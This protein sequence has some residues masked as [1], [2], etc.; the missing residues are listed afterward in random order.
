LFYPNNL[1]LQST[2]HEEHTAAHIT[3]SLDV[4][5]YYDNKIKQK[6]FSKHYDIPVL[7]INLEKRKDRR[8]KMEKTLSIFPTVI[9]IEADYVQDNGALG[10]LQS[11]IKMLKYAI[12]HYPGKDVL[13]CEDD[14]DFVGQKGYDPRTFLF[15]F[16]EKKMKWDTLLLANH[17]QQSVPTVYKDL[18]RTFDSQT[19]S[20]Y[21]VRAGY[22]QNLLNVF[23]NSIAVYNSFGIWNNLTNASDQCWKVLQKVDMWLVPDKTI[24]KQYQDYSDIQK[25]IVNY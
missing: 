13:F 9:R 5:R 17:T 4:V 10:C 16:F 23:E 24:A 3:R 11:H 21:L 7:Y 25:T 12:E 22:I 6:E 1:S 2:I 20:C 18:D 15:N 19:C 8:Q 14:I